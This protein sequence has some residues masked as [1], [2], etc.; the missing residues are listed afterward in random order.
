MKKYLF[1]AAFFMACPFLFFLFETGTIKGFVKDEKKDPIFFSTILLKNSADSTLYKGEITN[2][3]GEFNFENIKDGNYFL[4]IKVMGFE[5]FVRKYIE[6]SASNQI[7]DLERIILKATSKKLQEVSV[8]A[9]KPFI[10]R[11]VDK[12]V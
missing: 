4:E 3:K 8:I 1:L 2:D 12:T 10:E 5:S 9:D 7:I 11:Q 6:I